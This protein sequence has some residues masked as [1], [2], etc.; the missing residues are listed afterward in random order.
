MN[1]EQQFYNSNTVVDGQAAHMTDTTR[2]S[3]P[4]H[5]PPPPY[6]IMLDP[7]LL[8]MYINNCNLCCSFKLRKLVTE[9]TRGK[10]IL[11]QAYT[12]LTSYYNSV[13][14]PPIGSSDHRSILLQPSC[15]ENPSSPTIRVQQREC[16]A[17]WKNFP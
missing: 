6:Q 4:E 2:Q 7:C 16:K 17:A 8:R 1:C 13:I 10:N 3:A 14:L 5:S 11:G 9:P 12:N 15:R